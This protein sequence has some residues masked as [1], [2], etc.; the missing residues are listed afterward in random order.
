MSVRDLIYS[1][2]W[3]AMSTAQHLR[4]IWPHYAV[5]H[6]LWWPEVGRRSGYG[7]GS[8]AGNGSGDGAGFGEGEG[9]GNGTGYVAGFGE[10]EGAGNGTG[11]GVDCAK[12]PLIAAAEWMVSI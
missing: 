11:Y 4:G 2:P 1:A 9:A 6:G 12:Q 8:G 10:G 7:N 3:L 5:T